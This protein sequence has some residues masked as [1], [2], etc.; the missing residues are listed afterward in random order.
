MT[1]EIGKKKFD[2]DVGSRPSSV[3]V[4]VMVAVGEGKGDDDDDSKLFFA[5]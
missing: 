5:K 1:S 2:V 4:V 3:G